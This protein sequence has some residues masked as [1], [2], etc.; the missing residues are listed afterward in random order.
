M[1]KNFDKQVLVPGSARDWEI[2]AELIFRLRFFRAAAFPSSSFDR[3]DMRLTAT[4][5]YVRLA[6]KISSAR[7]FAWA[8][9][10]ASTPTVKA[11]CEAQ[12]TS[13][14]SF[15]EACISILMSGPAPTN[16]DS[17]EIDGRKYHTDEWTNV[18]S[19]ILSAVPRRLHL[20]PN[21]P[22]S[23]TRQIIESRFPA[24]T[25]KHH[26]SL[27]PVVTV[28]QNF[29]SLGFP[30]DHPGRSRTDT[31]YINQG[32]VLRTHTSAHQADTFRANESAGY[33]ISADVYR[34][35]AIDRSHYPI[36][37]Q[38]EG[39]RLWDRRKAPHGNIAQ[40][41]QDDIAQ[42]PAHTLSV[43]DP[44]PTTHPVRNPLQSAHHTPSEASALAT[45]LKRTIELLVVEI[46]S[47]AA[48]AASAP[49][50][51]REPPSPTPPPLQVR[52]VEAYFPFTS[53]SWEL[54]VHWQG[55]WLELLGCG[56]V[57]QSLLIN[58]G[59]PDRVGWAFGLG[60]E[61]VA[62]LLFDIP[63]IRLFWSRDPRFLAQFEAEPGLARGELSRFVPFS[64]FPA[65]YKDV[66]FWVRGA[67]G[68]GE[69]RGVFMRMMLWRW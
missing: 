57:Q 9:N 23:I 24:P 6:R 32:T 62:M 15:P 50:A 29:D 19:T 7:G 16:P 37:H 42:L 65:C 52:W 33:T 67:A 14:Q 30:A 1:L 58:A 25:Y 48:A 35:D 27:F 60:L 8:S 5:R 39:A 3:N 17:L 54:E 46:F 31:Y 64:K 45:H 59:V 55:A 13:T 10:A 61:R 4:G 20:Q 44:N 26:N 63:D 69:P 41:I 36:F 56:I 53:P 18:P 68:D 47:R 12:S 22:I 49:L 38:M 51:A 28:A 2:W 40:A 21:H 11:Q 43:S 66:S 34:R